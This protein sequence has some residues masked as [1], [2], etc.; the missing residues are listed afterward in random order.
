M[1]KTILFTMLTALI[2][3]PGFVSCTPTASPPMKQTDN[4][5]PINTQTTAI[6][7]PSQVDQSEDGVPQEPL[8]SVVLIRCFE[9]LC[10]SGCDSQT[11]EDFIYPKD[12]VR[13]YNSEYS[14]QES[15][16]TGVIIN[17]NGYILTN[18]HVA[19]N[20][21]DSKG[22]P[23]C[24]STSGNARIIV[25]LYENGDVKTDKTNS[26]EAS[27]IAAHPNPLVDLAIIKIEPKE[28]REF[29][30]AVLGIGKEV[31]TREKVFAMGFPE[32]FFLE[33][34]MGI[35]K[36]TSMLPTTTE[37]IISAS[38]V[39]K[40]GVEHVQTD[41]SINHGNSGGPLVNSKG[42]V[43]GINTLGSGLYAQNLN[44]AI[45]ID[46]ATQFI[47][48]IIDRT[49]SPLITHVLLNI[50]QT[51]KAGSVKIRVPTSLNAIIGMPY[52]KQLISTAVPGSGYSWS[53]AEGNLP[54][55]LVLDKGGLLSGTPI[56]ESD[57]Q[58][59]LKVENTAGD[60]DSCEYAIKITDI[61]KVN[62]TQR[63]YVGA[64]AYSELKNLVAVLWYTDVPSTSQIQYKY[65]RPLADSDTSLSG[66]SGDTI[67]APE[68]YCV[69]SYCNNICGSV[70]NNCQSCVNESYGSSSASTASACLDECKQGM[71]LTAIDQKLVTEHTVYL[72]HIEC[73]GMYSIRVLSRDSAGNET[74]SDQFI[75]GVR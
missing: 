32:T 38:R 2:I 60:Q 10:G 54:P 42:E 18:K 34:D 28:N 12:G 37:G 39:N 8:A 57:S 62:E 65:M 17:K 27:F 41:A 44:F 70:C 23:I 45:R 13:P 21:Q 46:E 43:V 53:I 3:I 74:I 50:E 40:D 64:P 75:I 67:N 68:G 5:T 72:K 59:L 33:K 1:V 49:P 55:G 47:K 31:K 9:Q 6:T 24:N 29:P 16:G 7:K 48:K 25:S 56:E 19:T 20:V 58:V 69:G 35:S 15:G 4:Q 63:N 51:P 11:L 61:T 66:L 30:V 14:Y 26:Y 73:K 36:T 71:R 52:S 22:K